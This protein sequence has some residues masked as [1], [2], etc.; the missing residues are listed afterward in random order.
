MTQKPSLLIWVLA[1]LALVLA[2]VFIPYGLLGGNEPGFAIA[3][4]WLVFG[5]AVALMIGLGVARWRDQA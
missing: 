1:M 5:L 4:F 2:G 3:I